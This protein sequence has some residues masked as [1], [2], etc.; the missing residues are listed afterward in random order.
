MARLSVGTLLIVASTALCAC[1]DSDPIE[2]EEDAAVNDAATP[3]ADA[4]RGDAPTVT[5]DAPIGEEPDAPTGGAP[6]APVLPIYDASME[7]DAFITDAQ[8]VGDSGVTAQKSFRFL[9]DSETIFQNF[10]TPGS[11]MTFRND[12][13]DPPGSLSFTSTVAGTVK[14][15]SPAFS[16]ETWGV[17]PGARVAYIQMVSYK[18]RLVS[19]TNM[20]HSWA[21]EIVGADNKSIIDG[22]NGAYLEFESLSATPSATWETV[23][24]LDSYEVRGPYRESNTELYVKVWYFPLLAGSIDWRLDEIELEITYVLP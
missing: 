3:S 19:N 23:D 6:D 12:D 20:G 2:G 1:S 22:E 21:F 4:P 15:V 24:G 13:G 7:P 18:R 10:A 14:S 16:W 17:P 11:A 9:M 8:D 5:I